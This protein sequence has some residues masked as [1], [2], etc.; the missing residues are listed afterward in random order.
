MSDIQSN[1]IAVV[2]AAAIFPGSVEASGFWNDILAAKDMVTDIPS[3]H[4]LIDDYYDPDPAAP[5]KTYAH[6]GAFLGDVQFDPLEWGVPPS[7]VPATDTTQLLALIVAKQVLDDASQGQFKEMDK[8][9]ISCIL[10]VTS[11]Q[12]L[13]GTMVNRL[14]K[15]VWVKAL[16]EM[17][18]AE[19][20]V[21]EACQKIADNYVGW[22]ESTF[23]GLLG[24]VVAGRIAN[25]LDLGG[26]NCVTDAACASSFSAASMGINELLLG[27]SDMV[28]VGGC[29]TMNDIFMY[30]CF[31]KTPALSKSG[32]CRPFSDK[33]DGTL[34]GEGFGMVALKRLADA[35]RDGDRIYSVIRGCGASS[36][37]RSKSVYAPVP[38]GQAQSLRRA[39]AQAGYGPET[40]ELVEAH[41]TGTKAGDAAEFEGLRIAFTESGRTDKQWC[42]LGTVKSQIGHTKAAAGAAGLFKVVMALHHKVLPPTIKIDRPNPKLSLEES[43][44]YLNTQT[45]P[46]FRGTDHP[47][48]ASVSSFGFGG[49]NFHLALEEYTGA[50]KHAW[51]HRVS[52]TELVLISGANANDVSRRASELASKSTIDGFLAYIAR[53]SQENFDA[54][55]PARL[56]IVAEDEADLKD[57]LEKAAKAIAARPDET[58]EAPNGIYWANGAQAGK[59]AFL[60]PGQGS[61]YLGMGGGVA[62]TW[63]SARHPWDRVVDLDLGA[64]ARIQDVVYP[65][66]VF[67]K[68]HDK[69]NA[70]R[71]QRTEW[72][73][74]AI[75][76]VSLSYL[77]MLT[78]LGVTADAVGGHSFGEITALHHAGVF[79]AEDLIRIAR[80]RGELMAEAAKVPG[81]MTAVPRTIDIVRPFVDAIDGVVL[82]NH[83]GPKQI[84]LSGPTEAIEK[85]EAALQAA[86]IPPKRLK[87]ATAFHSPVVS[88]STEPFAAFLAEIDFRAPRVDTYSNS[89][90]APYPSEATAMR[91]RLAG[92]IAR[93]VRFVEQIEAMYDSGIR[94]FIEVGPGHTLT[95]LVGGILGDRD[96]RAVNVDRRKRDCLTSLNHALGRLAVGGVAVEVAKL[97]K[98]YAPIE[99]PH[100]RTK[101]KLSLDINGSNYGKPYPPKSGTAELPKPNPE[102]T[103]AAAARDKG[104]VIERVVEV[105]VE[106]R[107]EVPVHVPGPPQAQAAPGVSM[108]QQP[109]NKPP[110]HYAAPAAAPAD[111]SWIGAFQDAQRATADAHA[112]YQKAMADSHMAFLQTIETS[113][114]GLGA[115]VTGQP[116]PTAAPYAP[117]AQMP[118]PAPM[119]VQPPAP[120]ILTPAPSAP[121][122]QAQNPAPSATIPEW[123]PTPAAASAVNVASLVQ[124]GVEVV[125]PASAP[126]PVA[127]APAT[128]DLTSLMLKVVAEK[129]G[130]PS[131][132]LEM[133]MELESDL[134]VDSI[135]RVEILSAM[136]ERAPELP[137]VDAGEMAQL[138]T[139]EQ[140]VGYM[141]ASMPAGSSVSV[142]PSAAPSVDLEG[143]MLEVVAEKT[144]YPADMLGMHMELESD[145]G[146]DSIK[147]VEILSA[148]RERAPE[149]PEVDAGEMAQLQTLGQI[150]EYMRSSMPEAPATPTPGLGV[151]LQA[152]MLEVVAEKTGYPADMLGMHMEL[153]SDLGVDS[154]K[155]VEILSAMRERAPELPEV[156]AGEMAQLQTLGQIVEY[157]GASLGAPAAS[158]P[159]PGPAIDLEQLMLEVVAEKTGYPADMLGMH[160]ELESDLGVDSIKRVEILS[161]MRE[162]APELPEVD[163]GEMAQLQTLGQIVEYMRESSG[164]EPAA[165]AV[166][167]APAVETPALGRYILTAYEAPAS[168]LSLPGLQGKIAIIDGGDIGTALAADLSARGFDASVTDPADADVVLFLGGLA[169]G[170]GDET[171]A[172]NRD[173]F[174]A[175]KAVAKR[176]AEGGGLFVTVQDTGGDFGLSGSE[177]AWLGGLTGL[178]KTAAQEWPKSFLKAI[179]LERGER[180]AKVLAAAI[181]DELLSGG[182]E[183]EVGLRVDGTRLALRSEAAEVSGGSNKIDS[184]SVIVATGGARGVTATTLIALAQATQASFALLGRT[185]LVDEPPAANGV[186]GDGALKG[187]LLTAARDAGEKPSPAEI[188][189]IVRNI[190]ANRE[191]RATLAALEAA[192]SKASYL[193]VDVN[194]AEIVAAALDTIRRSLGPITGLVHGAGVLADKLILEKTPEQFDFV[195]DT[196]VRGLQTLLEAT[197]EDKL[198]AIVM[199]SSVA[200]RCGNQ[201][202]CDY[203]MANEILN[204]VAALEAG[205]R[206]GCVVKSMGWG[207]WAGGMVT[208]ALKAHFESL[209]VP[210]IPLDAGGEM[211]VDELADDS[212]NVELVLGGE[213][214][215]GPLALAHGDRVSV[216]SLRTDKASHPYLAD[217]TI[218]GVPVVPVVMALEW[219]ARAA[220]SFRPDL[221][222]ASFEDIKVLRGI[223][224]Q[225]FDNG[226]DW[227]DVHVKEISNGQ[228]TMLDL[229]L[230]GR[231]GARYYSA[232]AEMT[233]T[234]QTSSAQAP[235]LDLEPW[236]SEIYDG[237]VLFHGADFQVIKSLDGVSEQGIAATLSSTH[238][239]G[240]HGSH[241]RTDPAALDGGLQLALLWSKHVLGGA[242]LPMSVGAYNTFSQGA[243][244]GSVKAIL[245]GEVKGKDRAVADIVFFDEAGTILAEM[246]DVVTVLRPGEP[247]RPAT[248]A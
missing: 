53:F 75:G 34:L 172:V 82:A 100:H 56:A 219:F 239:V 224:L 19:A 37:G 1:P 21:Q 184:S 92:Q 117:Q 89:E 222:L 97:W 80:K 51:R 205:R 217:H 191:I 181:A 54:S 159:A 151:D 105:P 96:Y 3:S 101:P 242:S 120:Q 143:L 77:G 220:S 190:L 10:G 142:A 211:L 8:S 57:K 173:G 232:T 177:R 131:D 66:P 108:S 243:P 156:D 248:Q 111:A 244:S 189:K 193:S 48:R 71:L 25:R 186:D 226:G 30:M 237:H 38:K 233:P 229:E 67:D 139:L 93:P 2:G 110:A 245:R 29:D 209:G 146:V 9:R 98:D 123:S 59:V 231:D 196:K 161:A 137:E 78:D 152:L 46:W 64:E 106:V 68:S 154:I 43:P 17:G 58:L 61:Q 52:P 62:M 73:Q 114:V 147:R 207:P 134:G 63:D 47:R 168:G 116:I 49:S 238:Q 7:I 204:K 169:D 235:Q 175:A 212:G 170:E 163:A 45:R 23:P 88:P 241:W 145:L 42:A 162:R 39:Y 203:A 213:P 84:V 107:V 136:R 178:V 119:P 174:L 36:D 171:L 206:N 236:S 192:G 128:L 115:M 197:K 18:Y 153:E 55:Q 87:V 166:E 150:V 109:T 183:L 198:T 65:Q 230:R 90:A 15:P 132:M 41:G 102:R 210:L 208:P 246:R 214:R 179:D 6:R 124:N 201:G 113:F 138:Q 81:A 12:E 16:R 118:A 176:F 74:P 164:D 32:D 158:A 149:L 35:E 4:W 14:Q 155:R 202:Q 194:D 40:V 140:I 91:E 125:N 185:A 27:Q 135:K 199:F 240:W 13:L 215:M 112:A 157:M 225:G 121:N 127:T 50:G 22:Q 218:A 228:G 223:K 28:I 227:L 11:A 247:K 69:A 83:N 144:G 167:A 200:A 195:F 70:E 94:T 129:T 216:L 60:F 5:D 86:D 26:T 20:E 234:Q 221:A 72:A 44:F 141:Q 99:D 130:Y 180:D 148:M 103:G 85:V 188:G 160:M 24:N 187:A 126:A 122:W 182:S 95:N 165:A 79:D 133:H 31:S 76:A 33:A 104:Q